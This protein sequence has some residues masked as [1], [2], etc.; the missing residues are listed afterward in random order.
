MRALLASLAA[1]RAALVAR[2][3][4][5]RAQIAAGAAG[6]RQT[7]AAPLA[8]GLGVALALGSS[9]PRLRAWLVRAWVLGAFVRRLLR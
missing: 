5:Q 8:L 9:S 6:V 2:S 4:A 3:A 7:V 1:R